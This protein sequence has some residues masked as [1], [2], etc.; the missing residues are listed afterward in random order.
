M[1]TQNPCSGKVSEQQIAQSEF[2]E[3]IEHQVQCLTLA[4]QVGFDIKPLEQATES[5]VQHA[6][7]LAHHKKHLNKLDFKHLIR[8]HGWT[9]KEGKRY[10]KVAATFAHL[11]PQQ[12][13][14]IEPATI[15]QLANNSKKYQSVIDQL[16]S[17]PEINQA[18][19]R[20]LMDATRKP[21]L[22]KEEKP[23][24]WRTTSTG[25]RYVQV[26]PIRE[27]QETGVRLQNMMETEGKTAQAIIADAIALRQM[28]IEGEL[29]LLSQATTNS[30]EPQEFTNINEETGSIPFKESVFIFESYA[31]DPDKSNVHVNFDEYI[32][33]DRRNHELEQSNDSNSDLFS[34][35]SK[36]IA[37]YEREEKAS[38]GNQRLQ[39]ST[40]NQVADTRNNLLYFHEFESLQQLIEVFQQ[41]TSWSEIQSTLLA[42]TEYKIAAWDAL[43]PKEQRQVIQIMPEKFNILL[44]A[45]IEGRIVDFREIRDEVYQVQTLGSCFWENVTKTNFEAFLAHL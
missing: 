16:A 32:E 33:I 40:Q 11:S 39:V 31:D 29:V 43:T 22:P 1:I 18:V 23:S 44:Q 3:Y 12:L 10:L 9:D 2:E 15:Y 37:S 24:I 38:D 7:W 30:N 25:E 4:V 21:K 35:E 34:V 36:E 6:Q 19:V 17:L 20:G 14:Q 41:A 42:H 27:D 5:I 13:K 8:F 28:Y 45:Q 26:P